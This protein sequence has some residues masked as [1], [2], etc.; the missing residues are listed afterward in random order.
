M[1][2]C[3]ETRSWVCWRAEVF[4]FDCSGTELE[5]KQFC[6]EY[7]GTS[8]FQFYDFIKSSGN[9]GAHVEDSTVAL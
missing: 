1:K 8:K 4:T 7:V 3:F 2:K 9:S 6:D 5:Q